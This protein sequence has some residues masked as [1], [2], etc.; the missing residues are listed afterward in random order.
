[1]AQPRQHIRSTK[2]ATF[3]QQT[4]PAS[5]QHDIDIFTV[6]LNK[7]FTD[8]TG[9]FHPRRAVGTIRPFPNKHDVHRIAAY[10]DIHVRL[11]NAN[12]KPMVHIMDNEAS[13]A[14]RQAIT[15]NGSTFQLV[16]P[17]VH[18]RNAAERAIRT[19]KDHFLAILAGTA[20]SFPADRWDLLIPHAELTLNLLRASH[21]NPTL[22]AWEDLFGPFNF[23]ATP[24]GPAGCRILIHSKATTRRSWDYRSHEGFYVGPALHHYRCYRVLNKES[25]SVAITD[26]IKFRHHYLPTPDLTAE[27]KIIAALQQLQ[28]ATKSPAAQLHA[29]YK[30]RDIFRH[31]ATT[32]TNPDT[33][34]PRG[35]TRSAHPRH[36]TAPDPNNRLADSTRTHPAWRPTTIDQ[37]I[38]ARTRARLRAIDPSRNSFAALADTTDNESVGTAMPV[39]DQD[40]GQLLEHKQLRRH[41]KHKATW[42]TSYSNELGRLCQGIGHHPV[43]K[44]KKRIDG[45]DTFKPIQYRDIPNQRKGDVTYTRVVCEIRPQKADPYR[46][47]ITLGGDRIRYPGD[48]GT[49]AGSL[50][51]VKLLL[52]SV[53]STPTARFASFDIS[54]FYLGTPLDRPEY[55]RIKLS[56]IPDDF[57]QEYSLHDFAHNGYVYSKS[58]KA[59]M[60]SNKLAN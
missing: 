25:R 53:L 35:A 43:H 13:L 37:P 50:E 48:C 21:C 39:L 58:P 26:A 17:H 45:T 52:N 51:T 46:T 10:Q 31:Y 55:A 59:S 33:T 4:T 11:C 36:H 1:M 32:A 23:D 30:L 24:L 9:R 19:F 8:D 28:L 15:S 16:P 20:P 22:S 6:P 14:F 49:K 47:R 54:N 42:D 40:T 7:I 3:H 56:D 34:P 44:H 41:P 57:V 2:R 5:P 12:R 60:A 27:D 29:I 38:A 18:R